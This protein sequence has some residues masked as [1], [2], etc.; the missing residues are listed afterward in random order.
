MVSLYLFVCQ[1]KYI[2]Y[3]YHVF[4]IVE[5]VPNRTSASIQTCCRE[6]RRHLLLRP[7]VHSQNSQR[8]NGEH[9]LMNAFRYSCQRRCDGLSCVLC[10][11]WTDSPGIPPSANAHQLFK[12][13][14]FVAPV[15]LEEG[16]SAPLVNILPLVQ[17][18]H[19][20]ICL[21]ISELC[22]HCLFICALCQMH[23]GAAQFADVYELKEDIGVGSYSICKRCI[24]RVTTM[25]F[26]VKVR[27]WMFMCFN[28]V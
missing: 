2:L 4:V 3:E 20:Y 5:T 10:V 19:S 9:V 18:N 15:S 26:A 21:Y 23:G 6:T 28:P 7:R 14:S 24:H 22:M 11:C 17:V 8:C 13:F 1:F 27:G 25:E 16:K 12:G